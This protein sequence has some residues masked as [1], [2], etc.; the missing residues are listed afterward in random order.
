MLYNYLTFIDNR[1]TTT[2][3]I[4]YK[5][6]F[7][8]QYFRIFRDVYW[9]DKK[10]TIWVTRPHEHAN[11]KSQTLFWPNCDPVKN[12]I[13]TRFNRKVGIIFLRL[14]HTA[15]ENHWYSYCY[16]LTY[17][18]D[19]YLKYKEASSIAWSGTEIYSSNIFDTL[20]CVIFVISTIFTALKIGL[21]IVFYINCISIK[22]K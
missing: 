5:C 4:L 16:N 8:H 11:I 19:T 9:T 21:Y 20:F 1:T 10:H 6:I 17:K 22:V 15:N 18:S 7:I 13:Q 14:N 12:Q 3:T 2:M